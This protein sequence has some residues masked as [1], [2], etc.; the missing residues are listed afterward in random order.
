MRNDELS[1]APTVAL[2]LTGTLSGSTSDLGEFTAN[3]PRSPRRSVREAKASAT[4]ASVASAVSSASCNRCDSWGARA[5]SWDASETAGSPSVSAGSVKS[6]RSAEILSASIS[7]REIR[8]IGSDGS[9]AISAAEVESRPRIS[10]LEILSPTRG[11]PGLGGARMTMPPTDRGGISP[12]SFGSSRFV[13]AI[14]TL[15]SAV[16]HRNRPV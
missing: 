10:S 3:S 15:S 13:S 7:R 11:R 2:T 8:P 5:D 16:S 1:D 9:G 4:S 12:M 14:P 6:A